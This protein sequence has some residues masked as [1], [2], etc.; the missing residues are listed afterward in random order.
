M[1]PM[2]VTGSLVDDVHIGETPIAILQA[3]N[4]LKCGNDPLVYFSVITKT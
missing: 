1:Y 4:F 3:N 2:Q